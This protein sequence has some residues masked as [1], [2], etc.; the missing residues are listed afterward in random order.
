MSRRVAALLSTVA[1]LATVGVG[2]GPAALSST[3]SGAKICVA[4]VVDAADLGGGVRS[5]CATIR[6]G[7]TGYDVLTAAGHTFTI[8]SNGVLGE[9]DGRPANGCQVKDDTH[10]WTYWHR[11]PDSHSWTYSD[12]GGGTYQ[13]RNAST[14]GWRWRNG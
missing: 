5:T 1:V 14:E 2:A 8:C 4:L 3:S 10:Y 6:Q 7:Q 9:I 12:E 13:P 11:P